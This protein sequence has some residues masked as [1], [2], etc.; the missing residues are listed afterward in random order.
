MVYRRWCLEKGHSISNPSIPKIA[1]FILWLCRSKGLSLSA[2]KAHRC[3]LSAV[4][5]LKLPS[6][7]EDS[8]L[9]SLLRSFTVERPRVPLGFPS[10][11]LDVVLRHLM[12]SAYKPLQSQSL[13]TLTKKVL[14]LVALATLKR[15]GKLQT[16]SRVVP[17]SGDDVMLFYLP[18]FV[19]KTKNPSNPLPLTVR[20]RS[21]TD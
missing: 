14:F 7:G 6:I 9:W 5:A 2:I 12:S 16:L 10:W 18:F 19:V 8:V 4:F 3:M 11:D 13:R 21:L 20:L 1:D 15:V 17:S